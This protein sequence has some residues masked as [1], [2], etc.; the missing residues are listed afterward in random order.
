VLGALSGLSLVAP[1]VTISAPGPNF[2][3]SQLVFAGAA[4]LVLYGTFV[5]VQTV[6]HRD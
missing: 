1:K 4:S 6:R 2:S 5:F 3:T